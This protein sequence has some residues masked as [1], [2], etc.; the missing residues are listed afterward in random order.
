MEGDTVYK[1]SHI[2][3]SLRTT[4]TGSILNSDRICLTEFGSVCR[5][6]ICLGLTH[7]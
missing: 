4:S 5:S 7:E 1:D 3:K 6:T 2:C